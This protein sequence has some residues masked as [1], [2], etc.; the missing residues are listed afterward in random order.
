[1]G[2]TEGSHG[3]NSHRGSP[4]NETWKVTLTWR[5]NKVKTSC[6]TD[7]E[8]HNEHQATTQWVRCGTKKNQVSTTQTV[9]HM[10]KITDTKEK[11][12]CLPK[13]RR[14]L[15]AQRNWSTR[16]LHTFWVRK[17]QEPGASRWEGIYRKWE[18]H[19]KVSRN[20]TLKKKLGIYLNF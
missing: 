17:P 5:N 3:Q 8:H 16:S 20:I 18:S 15:W 14:H 10:E 4:I 9:Q 12:Y 13:V 1:M 2:L 19:M 11:E 7:M 6:L